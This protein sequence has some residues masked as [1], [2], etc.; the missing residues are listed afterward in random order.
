MTKCSSLISSPA[1]EESTSSDRAASR[2]K[3]HRGPAIVIS[4]G[5]NLYNATSAA[6]A[7]RG[8]VLRYD[9]FNLSG[10]HP[11]DT[12]SPLAGV[13]NWD[14]AL[15]VGWQLTL[16]GQYDQRNVEGGDFWAVLVEQRLAPMLLAAARTQGGVE[17]LVG[18]AYGQNASGLAKAVA[19]IATSA[20]TSSERSDAHALHSSLQ[21]FVT[22]PERTRTSVDATIQALLRAF[23]FT[24]VAAS[25]H[26][27]AI[28]PEA[29]FS[30]SNTVYLVGDAKAAKLLRPLMTALLEQIVIGAID[31]PRPLLIVTVDGENVT[32]TCP[33]VEALVGAGTIRTITVEGDVWPYPKKQPRRRLQFRSPL[34]FG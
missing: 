9:P 28:T 19:T 23:R 10:G 34:T 24:R 4:Y 15:H 22:Q 29:L 21:E 26:G 25:A 16:A 18:W 5:P 33:A 30:G 13:T 11:G 12:W 1:R 14:S 2:L 27:S 8:N 3:R 6:R 31:S 20:Q 17:T 7:A 32:S